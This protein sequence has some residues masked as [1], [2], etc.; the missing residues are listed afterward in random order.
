[1]ADKAYDA[2]TFRAY[3]KQRKIKIVIP[4]KANRKKRIAT[5]QDSLQKAQCHRA[6]LWT[7]EGF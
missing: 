6:M 1:M 5:Q 2:N 4:G 3:L 7:T